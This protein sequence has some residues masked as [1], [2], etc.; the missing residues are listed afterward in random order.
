MGTGI[1]R[2][3]VMS[4]RDTNLEI[5]DSQEYSYDYSDYMIHVQFGD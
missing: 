5:S 1:N 2:K 3:E 4:S